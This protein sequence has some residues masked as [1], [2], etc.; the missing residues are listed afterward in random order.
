MIGLVALS[1][2]GLVLVQYQLL[3]TGLLLE[4]GKID[5]SMRAALAE[6][7]IALNNSF[8][9]QLLVQRLHQQKE[10]ALASPELLI[11]MRLEDSLSFFID[12]ALAKRGVVLEYQLGVIAPLEGDTLW[13][14][15]DFDQ[16]NYR[17][18]EYQRSLNG[19]LTTTCDCRPVLH[20]HVDHLFN[21]LLGQLAILIVPSILFLLLLVF[22]LRWLIR[23]LNRQRRLDEVK[24]DFINNLTHELKTPVFSSS[25]LI[26]MVR[27]R[28]QGEQP[29]VQEY[30][31]LMEKENEQ[32]KG[33][34]EKVL[35]LAS[36][37]DGKYRLDHQ[38]HDVHTLITNISERY[39]LKLEEAGGRLLLDLKAEESMAMVDKVHIQNT[40]QNII[41][42]AIKYNHA[43]LQLRIRTFNV[44][45]QLHLELAD[46]GI[47][48]AVEHQKKI[49][50]KFYRIPTG[51]LHNVKGF[52]LGLSY[53]KHI[54][55]AH[56]GQVKVESIEG[57][58]S[59]FIILLPFSRKE[60]AV[61]EQK[62]NA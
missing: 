60:Q 25:L 7:N 56:A 4:K 55:E 6:V 35:E 51:D 53:V 9:T 45:D 15:D 13:L 30:L 12:E 41:E 21:Y 5:Q 50:E 47:G 8:E 33:H 38:L 36:L 58:G 28:L 23:N 37:E 11:P 54:I 59:T 49:F 1:L 39:H 18:E 34:I 57:K 61:T 26:K 31:Q 16:A 46:D 62:V 10:R 2:M 40:L 14:T 32:M 27:Q 42:N 52:G 43:P 44:E 19:Q 24:N 22:C 29:K 17:Y 3:R 48:I 20:L